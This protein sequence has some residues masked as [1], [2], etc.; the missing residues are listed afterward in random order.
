MDI[1]SHYAK[2]THHHMSVIDRLLN[3]EITT[4]VGHLLGE[5]LMVIYLFLFPD[6]TCYSTRMGA[7]KTDHQPTSKRK[8]D[9]T[10]P[11][12]ISKT[13]RWHQNMIS[14]KITHIQYDIFILA[15]A[16]KG[17]V[18]DLSTPS[19][20]FGCFVGYGSFVLGFGRD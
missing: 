5:T 14:V 11:F 19:V 8:S 3:I 2:H 9:S 18:L 16:G 7:I 15:S 10:I 4:L 13:N 20:W 17:V 12:I 6:S 1:G